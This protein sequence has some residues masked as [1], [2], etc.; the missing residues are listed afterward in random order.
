MKAPLRAAVA[1]LAAAPS[2]LEYELT[3]TLP[4]DTG[5]IEEAILVVCRH[6]SAEYLSERAIRFNL[7]IALAEALANAILYGN[8]CDPSRSVQVRVRFGAER[9]EVEVTDEGEGFE[10][11]ELP[12]PL[13]E[14]NLL[15]QSGRGLLLIKA[16]VD[17]FELHKAE[18][19]L[20]TVVRLAVHKK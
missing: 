3:L 10:L 12:D 19:P 6:L 7:R 1:P 4:S 13:A 20:G 9:V 11:T 5:I 8:R 14:E 18:P 17:E 16:F 2:G 15:R